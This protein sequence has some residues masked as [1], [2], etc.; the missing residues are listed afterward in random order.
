MHVE[1]TLLLNTT[2]NFIYMY[3]EPMYLSNLGC[4][5]GKGLVILVALWLSD[6]IHKNA[7]QKRS[8]VS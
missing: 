7:V 8:K 3:F 1:S 5:R 4:Q 6:M 2:G